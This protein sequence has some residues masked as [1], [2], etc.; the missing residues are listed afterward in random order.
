MRAA[1]AEQPGHALEGVVCHPDRRR[2]PE[3]RLGR[4]RALSRAWKEVLGTRNR[5]SR[6]WANRCIPD[7]HNTCVR[8]GRAASPKPLV[9]LL[10]FY[11]LKSADDGPPT[12]RASTG[13]R[14]RS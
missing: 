13:E 2:G 3:S 8:G 1:S 6:S 11:V 12:A 9:R 5:V 14:Q 4:E 7:R 10:P